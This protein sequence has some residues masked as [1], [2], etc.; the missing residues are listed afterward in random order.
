MTFSAIID[1][2]AE[3]QKQVVVYTAE[4]TDHDLAAQL[5]T[6]NVTVDSRRLPALEADA[7]VVVREGDRF[8][9]AVALSDLLA[10]VEPPVR[11][12]DELDAVDPAL[13][14]VYELLD[15]TVFVALTRRQLLATSRELEDRAWRTG[16]GQ[17]HAGFQSASALAAQADLYAELA[18]TTD[19]EVHVYVAEDAATGRFDGTTVRVHTDPRPDVGRF[20][21]LLFEDGTDGTQDC[22][23]V[24]EQTDEA[25]YRGFWTYDPSLVA[26]ALDVVR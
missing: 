24:A 13:R 26:R 15:E 23:L 18:A 25:S 14:A 12:P 17:L 16:R 6:R 9:G 19:V 3:G 21:F 10:F 22:A 8:C 7:F 1:D 2:I 20:W 11:R 4:D 5:L